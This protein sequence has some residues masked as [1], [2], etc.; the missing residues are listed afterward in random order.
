M[1]T[2]LFKDYRILALCNF[3]S[4]LLLFPDVPFWCFALSMLFWAW[5]LFC[6][7]FDFNIPSRYVTGF[8]SFLGLLVILLEFR[9]IMG[10]EPAASFIIILTGLKMLEFREESEKD[11]LVLLGF[12][13]ISSKFLFSYDLSYLFFSIPIYAGLTI[14]LF[15]TAWIKSQRSSAI[16]Y[17]AKVF[18]LALP[19][20]AMMFVF[21]PR[22]T[23]KLLEAPSNYRF[24]GSG[25]SDSISPGSIS[26]LR[27]NNEVALR[28]E[29]F[30]VKVNMLDLYLRGLT[31]EKNNLMHWSSTKTMDGFLKSE[32]PTETDY[33]IIVE[34]HYKNQIFSLKNTGRMSAEGM[35][36]YHDLH[37]NFR[38]ESPL[39]KKAVVIGSI[40]DTRSIVPKDV[41]ERNSAI[42]SLGEVP[43]EQK[44]QVDELVAQLSKN[45]TREA[46]SRS[47]M[48]YFATQ[49]FTYTL[50]PGEQPGL[51]LPEFIFKQKKGYCE[52][53]A[54]AM[55]LLLR[56]SKVPARVV[57]GYQGGEFNPVGNFWTVRQKD[58][59]AWVEFINSQNR[60]VSIDP[61]S[62]VAPRRLELGANI[63][64]SL[65]N[66]ML[67]DEEIKNRINNADVISQLSMW[68]DNINYRW[69]T[70]LLEYD[71]DKQKDILRSL[72]VSLGG[73]LIIVLIVLFIFSI[74]INVYQ[75]RGTKKR[76][77]ELCFIE[78]NDWAARF[79]LQKLDT[80]GP[81][82]WLQ[83]ILKSLPEKNR[84]F[85]TE[86][87]Q[88]FRIWIQIAY[89]PPVSDS[90]A[91]RAI[92]DLRKLIRKQP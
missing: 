79:N 3:I 52:H 24:G 27:Q 16:K 1:N 35:T 73:S 61:V 31:L 70:F 42:A 74:L 33:K 83:R 53:Y 21:F 26:R 59:H 90:E 30:N 4:S 44:K 7:V 89:Q 17:L 55:A 28:L 64:N 80:E 54:S 38:F 2:I 18:L 51:T 88:A 40:N 12:F 76:F 82:H 66:D 49:G 68:F 13:L 67:T 41:I 71:F 62:V 6:H 87:E 47:I 50:E 69:S 45:K 10:K 43:P 84:A 22:I 65:L 46:I 20:A 56:L 60:W 5:R 77:S 75:R 25:F 23:K 29:T 39:E 8:L 72:N 85:Q 19:M 32:A 9:T 78:L 36:I 63:Y 57:V 91:K 58:A 15:P 34:P 11:F 86:I 48:D 81:T 14:N 92:G 37:Y